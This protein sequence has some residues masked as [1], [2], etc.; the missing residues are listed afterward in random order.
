MRIEMFSKYIS[1]RIGACLGL[2][3]VLSV[4]AQVSLDVKIDSVSRL[5][6]EQAH[7][8]LEVTCPQNAR[9]QMPIL[10]DTLTT[11]VELLEQ[12]NPDTVDNNDIRKISQ[13]YTITSFD[14]A[15]YYIPPFVVKVNGKEYSSNSL[16]LKVMTCDVDTTRADQFFGPK[17]IADLPFSWDDW[18][19]SIY[20]GIA[21]LI[22]L[23]AG[24]YLFYGYRNNKPILRRIRREKKLSPHAQAMQEI[25]RIK[26]DKIAAS[27]NSKEYYT[28]LTDTLRTYIKERYGFNAME[29]TSTEIIEHL[30]A[31]QDEE[32]L[33]E[34]R[35]LFQT[36]DLVK[37]ARYTALMNENDM[38]LLNAVDFINHT[39]QEEVAPEKPEPE[40]EIVADPKIQRTRRIQLISIVLAGIII[41]A[42]LAYIGW[43]V[44]EVCY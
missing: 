26:E 5:I 35:V 33:R 23:L 42:L 38:N 30:Q 17:E 18:E 31:N 41:L 19:S 32:A 29:M 2:V 15:V 3:L 22:L 14:S 43:R 12:S 20:A 1:K 40:V 28:R 37:F 39:K 10:K 25:E 44:Y 6:G 34:L 16:A 11:G 36:A 4:N 24:G 9:V 7:I 8:T 21:I 27:E 13:V